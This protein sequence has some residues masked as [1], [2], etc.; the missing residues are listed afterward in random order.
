MTKTILHLAVVTFRAALVRWE[1][2]CKDAVTFFAI[3]DKLSKIFSLICNPVRFAKSLTFIVLPV[4]FVVIAVGFVKLPVTVSFA[5]REVALITIAV[6]IVLAAF[7]MGDRLGRCDV[8]DFALVHHAVGICYSNGRNGGWR[9]CRG[10]CRCKC[11]RSRAGRG[12]TRSV[13][14]RGL[15]WG[16]AGC[17]RRIIWGSI[18]ER[19]RIS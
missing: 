17:I 14:L 4:S 7:A 19:H 2:S 8:D 10:W 13:R 5:V 16:R 1:V 18:E 15:N 3:L 11:R 12:W 6:R 9:R